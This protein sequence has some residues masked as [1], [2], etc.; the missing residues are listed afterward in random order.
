M[1]LHRWVHIDTGGYGVTSSK[2]QGYHAKLLFNV[3]GE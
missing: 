2:G 3:D 1:Q